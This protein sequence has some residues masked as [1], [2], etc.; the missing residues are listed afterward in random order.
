[1]IRTIEAKTKENIIAYSLIIMVA[2]VIIFSFYKKGYLYGS[3]IDWMAQHSTIPDYFRQKFYETGNLFPDFAMNLGGGQ[4][5]YNLSYYGFLSPIIL[6]SYLLPFVSMATFIA[7][8]S[9]TVVVLSACLCYRWL[10]NNGFASE[11]AFTAAM[12]FLTAGPVIFQSHHQVMFMNYFLFLFI[13][14]LGIDL[15]FKSQK[16]WL[17]I[18]SIFLC[19]MTS[20]FFSVGC[21]FTMLVYTTYKYRQKVENFSIREY[22]K[23]VAP[24]AYGTLIAILMA[25]VLWLP[26]I[27][28]ILHGRNV[29]ADTIAWL[30][31]LLPKEPLPSLLFGTYSIGLSLI[32]PIALLAL[33]LWRKRGDT[34]LTIVLLLLLT[35]PIFEYL[36]NGTLYV[37]AKSLIPFL[38][39]YV[40]AIA[41]FLERLKPI[42]LN[43]Q[44]Q[45]ERSHRRKSLYLGI[46]ILCII[47]SI[48]TSMGVNT[49]DL[50]V[51][52]TDYQDVNSKDKLGLIDDILKNDATFYRMEDITNGR[53]TVN[54]V[55][56]ARFYQPTIYTSTLNE[57]YN[58][59]YYDV[60]HNPI[61]STNRVVCV[62]SNNILF[63]NYMN[64]KYII[65][66]GDAPAG[67]Q[68][69]AQKGDYIVF[70]NQ[71]TLSLGFATNRVLSQKEY[72][73]IPFP[74]DIIEL[75]HGIVINKP[76]EI[77]SSMEKSK[78]LPIQIADISQRLVAVQNQ[79]NVS[80]RQDSEGYHIVAGKNATMK[81]PLDFNLKD[82][83][84]FV[85]FKISDKDNLKSLNTIVT[86][87][88]IKNKLS[89]QFAAY[90]NKNNNFTYILSS[91]VSEDWLTVE[92]SQGKYEISGISA[93]I[94]PVSVIHGAIN[95]MDPFVV[96]A[97]L[98]K[99]NLI[100]GEIHVS[101]DGYF[102]T[103][104]PYD[105]GFHIFVDGKPQTYEKVNTAFIGF[106]IAKGIHHIEFKYNSPYK[107]MG[108]FISALGF[109]LFSWVL[110][111]QVMKELF[112]R[113][114]SRFI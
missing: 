66:K 8:S 31:L 54:K 104:I 68:K 99:D 33:L 95:K 85:Q 18:V 70:K 63:Q 74:S 34:F 51:T 56:R 60:M 23:T 22:I 101:N 111:V 86:I 45:T 27:Y 48:G 72:G 88:G 59:F 44:S 64:I 26:T 108:L 78:T 76:V 47:G 83:I 90:P 32:A 114:R 57:A 113:R 36:L 94:V 75:F 77:P 37:R 106:P 81:I 100:A 40:L 17:V 110:F 97:A 42:L 92:F 80:I 1:M 107:T 61:P 20:Y 11:I 4:N 16:S 10:K 49:M 30:P 87:N 12:C 109:L 21:I 96:D 50:L 67:Y 62:A 91:N 65:S 58:K 14:L 29:N 35:F 73:T 98:T 41:L 43:S 84:L 102:A 3:E 79:K 71:Q 82:E 55:Y 5:I 28:V 52:T 38:P 7:V 25:A 103:S 19:I 105:V 46:L 112:R 6:I 2:M 93:Y 24:L 53:Y 13:G 69:I 89:N 15:F 39:L 9:I